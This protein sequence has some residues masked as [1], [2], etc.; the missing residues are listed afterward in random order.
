MEMLDIGCTTAE[1]AIYKTR[2]LA[3]DRSVRII[4]HREID[5]VTSIQECIHFHGRSQ[6]SCIEPEW[7]SIR[8]K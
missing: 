6:Q 4:T 5:P 8:K 7:N 2:M 3:V 1:K